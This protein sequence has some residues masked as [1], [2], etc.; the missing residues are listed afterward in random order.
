MI[1]A[2]IVELQPEVSELLLAAQ[3]AAQISELPHCRAA[4]IAAL[5]NT[6]PEYGAHLS[7]L[8]EA[9]CAFAEQFAFSVSDVSDTQ[10]LALREHLSESDVWA[11]VVAVYQLDME[12]RL[13]LLAEEVL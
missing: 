4:V 9:Q 3:D 11:F 10:V 5:E 12:T 13:A 2:G 8:Q 1:P 7:M 6:V